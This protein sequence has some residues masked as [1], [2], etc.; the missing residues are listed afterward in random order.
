M[1]IR[2]K[3]DAQI[4]V[5]LQDGAAVLSADRGGLLTLAGILAALAEA[6]PGEHVHLDAYNALEDGSAELIV[7]KSKGE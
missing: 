5:K 6:A 7:E 3:D 4:A 2:W 1:D